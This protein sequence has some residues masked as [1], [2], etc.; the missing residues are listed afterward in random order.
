MYCEIEFK[1]IEIKIDR[2]ERN[3]MEMKCLKYIRRKLK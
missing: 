1:K 2:T 3:E